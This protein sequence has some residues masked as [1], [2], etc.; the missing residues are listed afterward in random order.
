M[1]N[2]AT[3]V[4]TGH[5]G[6][7]PETRD[8]GSSKVTSFSVAVNTGFGERKNCTWY[9]VSIWGKSG[10]KAAQY[11]AKG[12]AVTVSGEP[13]NREYEKDG[14]KRFSL[15]V[16]NARWDFAGGKSEDAPKPAAAPVA[17]IPS[18]DIPF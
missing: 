16:N 17:D 3:I 7:E 5:L 15:E 9:R 1:P 10:E 12:D 8:A 18:D 13:C 14:E 11:L 4:I 6:S 2:H